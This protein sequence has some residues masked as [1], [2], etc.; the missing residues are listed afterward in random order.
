MQVKYRSNLPILGHCTIYLTNEKSI[1]RYSIA[2]RI[3]NMFM[4]GV[5][6][7]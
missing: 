1:K 7:L 5:V 3:N 2:I 6:K 4:Q